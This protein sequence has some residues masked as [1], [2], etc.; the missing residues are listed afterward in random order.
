MSSIGP[1]PPALPCCGCRSLPPGA[2]PG[3]RMLE[4]GRSRM[5]LHPEVDAALRKGEQE[6]GRAVCRGKSW[7]RDHF[8]C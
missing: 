2:A 8:H 6:R 5:A 4:A 7:K 1:S 3:W